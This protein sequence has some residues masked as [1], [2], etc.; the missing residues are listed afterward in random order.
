MPSLHCAVAPAALVSPAVGRV[1]PP[2]LADRPAWARAA[3]G[4]GVPT[5]SALPLRAAFVDVALLA[6]VVFAGFDDEVDATPPCPVHA[7]RPA[8]D[9]VPSTHFTGLRA[10][11]RAA[12][13]TAADGCVG[14]AFGAERVV[15]ADWAPAASGAAPSAETTD[16]K[17]DNRRRMC[18]AISVSEEGGRD[19]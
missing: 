18:M 6:G 1:A 12:A 9:D 10:E 15:G 8:T 14:W 7:P 2:G 11:V 13:P 16:A 3:A 4:P 19:I 5:E 17:R